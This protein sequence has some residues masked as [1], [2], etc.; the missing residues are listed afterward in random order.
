MID[1]CLVCIEGLVCIVDDCD[2]WV[3]LC[4]F[5]LFVMVGND[6]C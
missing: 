6:V 2:L 1:L 3:V 4:L 5:E